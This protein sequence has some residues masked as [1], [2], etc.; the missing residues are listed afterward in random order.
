M[1]RAEKAFH[2]LP[3]Q[4]EKCHADIFWAL[5]LTDRAMFHCI[6]YLRKGTNQ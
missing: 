2:W 6:S 1:L 5:V 3:V 4:R